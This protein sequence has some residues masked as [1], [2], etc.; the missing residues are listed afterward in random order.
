MW[1]LGCLWGKLEVGVMHGGVGEKEWTYGPI[2]NMTFVWGMNN[3][4]TVKIAF[5]SFTER[6]DS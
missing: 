1:V 2:F 6:W 3:V 4:T 5:W